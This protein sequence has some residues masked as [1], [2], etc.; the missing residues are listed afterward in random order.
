M[1]LTGT[2]LEEERTKTFKPKGGVIR[3][4]SMHL[5]IITPNH[6]GSNPEI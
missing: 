4:I 6:I 2:L 1:V 5:T 3:P